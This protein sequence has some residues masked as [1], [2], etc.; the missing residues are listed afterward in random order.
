SVLDALRRQIDHMTNPEKERAL[1]EATGREDVRFHM[2]I[3]K[4]AR[5]KFIVREILRLHLISRV[6]LSNAPVVPDE[7]AHAGFRARIKRRRFVHAA[8]ERIFHA[9]RDRDSR[10]ARDLME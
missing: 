3:M 4:A 9:I 10:L 2:A 6:A 8:H 7:A 5:N 1:S